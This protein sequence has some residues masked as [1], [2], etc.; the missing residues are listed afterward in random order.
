[1]HRCQKC[2]NEHKEDSIYATLD[3]NVMDVQLGNCCGILVKRRS[4]V[5]SLVAALMLALLFWVY[6]FT[7]QAPTWYIENSGTVLEDY[8]WIDFQDDLSKKHSTLRKVVKWP[9]EVV[10]VELLEPNDTDKDMYANP[11]SG[12]LEQ[13]LDLFW[14]SLS[15]GFKKTSREL[16]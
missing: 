6:E 12:V 13:V 11:N 3:D 9:G 15:F 8:T 2:L 10:K 1:M 5:K 16:F 7:N 4:L 14:S